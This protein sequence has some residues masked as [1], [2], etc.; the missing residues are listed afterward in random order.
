M[1][2]MEVLLVATDDWALAPRDDAEENRDLLPY[3]TSISAPG[4]LVMPV[5]V[6]SVFGEPT[7]EKLAFMLYQA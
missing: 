2:P 1:P 3:W 6:A 4:T 7:Q 5:E